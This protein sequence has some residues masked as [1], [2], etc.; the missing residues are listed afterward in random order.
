MR[1]LGEVAVLETQTKV[2]SRS[3]PRLMDRA[4]GSVGSIHYELLL[5]TSHAASL[6]LYF[7]GIVDCAVE[8]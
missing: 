3:S 2:I 6:F 5:D 4:Y 1:I 7:G 8:R